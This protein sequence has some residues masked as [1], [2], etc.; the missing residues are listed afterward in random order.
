MKLTRSFFCFFFLLLSLQSSAQEIFE[1]PQK[2]FN[3]FNQVIKNGDQKINY[4]IEEMMGFQNNLIPPSPTSLIVPPPTTTG[5]ASCE[6]LWQDVIF[7][8]CIGYNNSLIPFDFQNDG[9][10]DL[11]ANADYHNNSF[12]YIL[13][14]DAQS[15]NFEKVFIS[16]FYKRQI[17]KMQL[18]DIDENGSEELVFAADSYVHIFDFESLSVIHT[19]D[20]SFINSW[21][22]IKQIR[23]GDADND[24]IKEL[25]AGSNDNLVFINISSFEMEQSFEGEF[26]DFDIGNVD[27]D[28]QIETVFTHG[29]TLEISGDSYTEEYDFRADLDEEN[30]HIELTD[31]DADNKLEAIVANLWYSIEVYDVETASLKFDIETNIDIAAFS[32][33]DLNGDGIE[34]ILYGDGQWGDFHCHNSTT[35]WLIWSFDNPAHGSTGVTVADFDNDQNQEVVW[36]AGCSSSGSDHLFV[37]D[38]DD[39][40]LEWQ[41]QHIDGPYYAIEIED[42]DEDGQQE[43]IAISYESNSGDSGILTIYDAE[44]KAIE[45][46]SDEDFLANIWTGIYNIEIADYH[47]DGDLDIIVA[48]GYTYNGKLWVI[49]GNTHSIETIHQ[50]DFSS[51]IDAFFA[52][53]VDDIDGD[54]AL[55]LICA[56]GSKV[57]I[58]NSENFIIEWESEENSGF[59]IPK[60]LL[61]GNIDDDPESEIVYCRNKIYKFDN[62]DYVQSQSTSDQYSAIKL[63][64]WD[65][66]GNL[67]I[68]AGM[69]SGHIQIIEG[70]TME[71][72]ET[73]LI[74]PNAINGIE[75]HDLNGDSTPEIIATSDDLIYYIDH[76]GDYI[77]SQPIA[78][79]LGEYDAIEVTDYDQDGEVNIILG[80]VLAVTEVN[81]ACAECLWFAPSFDKIDATCGENNGSIINTSANNS[82]VFT[83]NDISFEEE[84]TGLEQGTYTVIANNENGCTEEFEISLEQMDLS[85]TLMKQD[86]TCFEEP[87]GQAYVVIQE[88][89]PPYNLLWSN[90]LQTDTISNLAPGQYS[91]QIIDANDCVFS[92]SIIIQQSMLETQ[93]SVEKPACVGMDNG[94]AIIT[95]QEGQ[96]PFEFTWDGLS[97]DDQNNNLSSGSHT[98]NIVDAYGCTAMYTFEIDSTNLVI[99]AGQVSASC[100]GEQDGSASV[101]ISVGTQPYEYSWNTGASTDLIDNLPSGIYA[102]TVEDANGCLRADSVEIQES[103]LSI[104]SDINHPECYGDEDGSAVVFVTE[105]NPPYNYQWNNGSTGNTISGVPAGDYFILVTDSLGCTIIENIEITTPPALIIDLNITNDDLET[106]EL[107][108]AIEAIV[109]GGTS[110]YSFNWSNGETINSITGLAEGSYTLTVTDIN[111]CIMD[112]TI[113]LNIV[114]AISEIDNRSIRIFPNPAHN[115]LIIQNDSGQLESF[116]L[117]SSEGKKVNITQELIDDKTIGVGLG[118]LPEGFYTLLLQKNGHLFYKKIVINR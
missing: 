67:E 48:A 81:P 6:I 18:I 37:Y 96:S 90:G 116:I 108:G 60:G 41:S 24:G 8:E 69:E 23:F 87:D 1:S 13:S 102:V 36:G 25:V 59:G 29:L 88:G 72:L 19:V 28:D 75:I 15:G 57:Y 100:N 49:D 54:N 3:Q 16:Q 31:V 105:G 117:F 86:K 44:T 45:F 14:Y 2:E 50:F 63:Y 11:I 30:G 34:E 85:A 51:D 71:V 95:I 109:S 89:L 5:E 27:G 47:S 17:T 97:G 20:L 56:T 40:I 101:N 110:P 118:D 74:S 62:G 38:L 115:Y 66:S 92:D 99:E 82:T 91:V 43:I 111:D 9:T 93:L 79:N 55:E 76:T 10:T 7:G 12:W 70:N 78:R 98:V 26:G 58:F 77:T 103:V 107:E 61:T 68:I 42:V 64:D 73:F 83:W 94:S 52:L 80:H 4:S 106:T 84:L 53:E 104:L 35:G 22:G 114:D 112:T 46:R 113:I 33:Q 32:L 39:D 21:Q 65:D